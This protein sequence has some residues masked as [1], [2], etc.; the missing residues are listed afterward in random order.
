MSE[1]FVPGATD[2]VSRYVEAHHRARYRWAI[3]ELRGTRGR[4]IDIASGAGYG[5]HML[6]QELD[7]EV[8]GIDVSA[9]AVAD[10][11]KNYR[12]SNLSYR[13][14]SAEALADIETGSVAALVSFET[15]EHLHQPRD[16][17]A[18]A[19]RVLRPN[20]SLLISTPNR[21]LASTMYPIRGRP[22]NPFHI[23]EYTARGFRT[24]LAERFKIDASCGQGYV[25]NWLAFWPV[26]VSF[27]A[28]C[29]ALRRTGA[30]RL[31][32]RHFHDPES[33]EVLPIADFPGRVPSSFVARCSPTRSGR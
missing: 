24:D 8:I 22:N 2:S 27:K 7:G 1:R 31:I 20:G 6:A 14:G 12:A 18:E 4:V 33:V 15:I 30:Y 21:L 29:H 9:Q 19:A 28:A 5:T 13:E 10:A 17:L 32:D 11:S 26:Q 16:F 3:G 23:F 25:A